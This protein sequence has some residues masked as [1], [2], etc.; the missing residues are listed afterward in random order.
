MLPAVLPRT[1]RA[2]PALDRKEPNIMRCRRPLIPTSVVA[3][4]AVAVLVGRLRRRQLDADQLRNCG[5]R[6]SA[7]G[8]W[9]SRVCMRSHGVPGYPDPQVS[10]SANHVQV[11]ISPGSAD[12]NSPAFKSA[13]PCMPQPPAQR[14]RP[15]QRRPGQGPE[16][17][18]RRLCPLARS[19][20]FPTPI[21][22]ERSP[23]RP[24]S[25]RKL[26]RS[27]TLCKPA[28]AQSRAHSRSIKLPVA[29]EGLARGS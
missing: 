16:P 20:D 21:A 1:Q 2:L 9:R 22:T 13:G 4:A 11:T 5:G 6:R 19:T 10:S 3:A 28:A 8:P 12:P 29:R 15:G 25:T 26:R 23:S 24:R 7:S 14:R 27:S 18:V 17:D